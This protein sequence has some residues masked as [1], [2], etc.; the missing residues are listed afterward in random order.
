MVKLEVQ[1]KSRQR[2]GRRGR[3]N[4][5]IK[6]NIVWVFCVNK[7]TGTPMGPPIDLFSA[8]NNFFSQNIRFFLKR[9]E[10]HLEQDLKPKYYDRPVCRWLTITARLST[11][12]FWTRKISDGTGAAPVERVLSNRR[13]GNGQQP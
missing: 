7:I 5:S 6:L 1:L 3:G 8:L 4:R 11:C 9:N 12:C 10:D 13:N 2:D